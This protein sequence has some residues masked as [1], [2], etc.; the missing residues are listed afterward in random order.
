MGEARAVVIGMVLAI[1]STGCSG[2]GDG[3]GGA[4]PGADA[5][6]NV[7]IGGWYRVTSDRAG[8]CGGTLAPVAAILS[9]PFLHLDAR[10]ST[11]FILRTCRSQAESDCPGTRYYDFTIPLTDG[12]RAEGGTAFFSAGCT[13]V[14][15]RTTAT[16]SGSELRVRSLQNEVH[17]DVPQT[18]CNLAAAEAL[19]ECKYEDEMTATR[20]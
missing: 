12:W 20:L 6:T 2:D 15:E 19:T 4:P 10:T 8:P 18:Q 3:G 13:L 9:P 7:N 17:R 16:L 14:W 11:G 1:V 5:A